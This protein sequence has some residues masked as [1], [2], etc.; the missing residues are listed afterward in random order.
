[1]VVCSIREADQSKVELSI[2]LVAELAPTDVMYLQIYNIM[3][4]K[5]LDGMGLEELGRHFY[6]YRQAIKIPA[7]RLELWPGYKTSM[8][9]HERNVMLC[10]DTTHKVLRTDSCLDRMNA[11]RGEARG[12]NE[13][14][15]C[16]KCSCQN[17]HDICHLP[18]V[19]TSL[20]ICHF[21]SSHDMLLYYILAMTMTCQI[22]SGLSIS[23]ICRKIYILT[24]N[25]F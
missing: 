1:M 25:F 6:D 11:I 3:I 9:N 7:H 10:V 19:L 24:G 13:R 4:R 21:W 18:T 16:H 5:C 15:R 17:C 14:V 20:S 8:R 23:Q 22:L 12:G 2:R